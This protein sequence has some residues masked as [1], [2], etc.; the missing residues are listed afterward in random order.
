MKQSSPETYTLSVFNCVLQKE[1]KKKK[2][3]MQML[4]KKL[5]HI[6]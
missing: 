3:M 4:A 6:N 2:K 5:G 1:L